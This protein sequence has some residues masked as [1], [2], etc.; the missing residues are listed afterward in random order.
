MEEKMAERAT[1]A[2]RTGTEDHHEEGHAR[3]AELTGELLMRGRS[4]AHDLVRAPR[5]TDLRP[6]APPRER[7]AAPAIP[8]SGL[9]EVG[10]LLIWV[11]VFL[12]TF[13][14]GLRLIS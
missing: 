4:R 9:R 13:L 14:I 3:A 8:G 12:G 5:K 2:N 11:S 10:L 6:P 7:E 1:I